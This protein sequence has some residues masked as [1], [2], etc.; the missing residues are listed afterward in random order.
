MT[1]LERIEAALREAEG[2]ACR[3]M[4][5]SADALKPVS[6]DLPNMVREVSRLVNSWI[7][8]AKLDDEMLE[9]MGLSREDGT[10]FHLY[11]LSNIALVSAIKLVFP[12]VLRA[13][14]QQIA[15]ALAESG[16]LETKR[17]LEEIA[18][19]AVHTLNAGSCAISR[20][21]VAFLDAAYKD[22]AP[23]DP[24]RFRLEPLIL[25]SREIPEELIDILKNAKPHP[26]ATR[27]LV[28]VANKKEPRK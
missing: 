12:H 14:A 19:F 23:N 17:L 24:T 25:S 5:E 13:K 4:E 27:P 18:Y 7:K 28:T 6:P 20:S 11:G 1:D 21:I 2:T 3:F 8:A 22:L 26:D 9:N 10:E 16:E 15:R